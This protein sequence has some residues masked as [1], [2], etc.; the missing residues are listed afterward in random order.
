LTN[1]AQSNE[2]VVERYRDLGYAV[3][4]VSNYQHIAAQDG[5][6]TM[7]LYEHGYNVGKRH[8]L[9]IGAREVEWFD[10]LL[11]Q[12]LSQRQYVI[13]RMKRTADLVAI[14]HPASRDAYTADDMA[15]LTGYDL[16]EIVNGPF[17]VEDV[18][19]AA[20]SA[21]RPVWGIANDDT[22]DLRDFRRTAVGWNM[23][24]SPSASTADIVAALRA[25]RSYAVLR[26][27]AIDSVDLT[28]LDRVDVHESTVSISVSGAEST[29]AFI[30]QNGALKK[31]VKYAMGASYTFADGDTYVRTVITSP[32]T[33]LYVN[34]IVR[35]DGRELTSPAATVDAAATWAIRA[36]WGV[37]SLLA[38]F[39]YGRRRRTLQGVL[40][41]ALASRKT[42]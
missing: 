34:P 40:R 38:V 37:G 31:T 17:A 7:P 42:A 35:Y 30:G 25:G 20:L 6:S 9:G 28:V 21:G 4:G 8:Q 26:T 1:G 15:Q 29:F 11:W 14:V 12:G 10:F 18:W 41:P 2:A 27:G 39:A 19:D 13:D 32:Q 36:G 33:V 22:H 5:V 16:I 24:G 3:P 23:V